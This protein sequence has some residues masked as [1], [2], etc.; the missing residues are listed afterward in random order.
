[1]RKTRNFQRMIGGKSSMRR[2]LNQNM[3]QQIWQVLQRASSYASTKVA[4]TNAL[5][6]CLSF[7]S[8]PTHNPSITRSFTCYFSTQCP[9]PKKRVT[10]EKDRVLGTSYKDFKDLIN[11]LNPDD[12]GTATVKVLTSYSTWLDRTFGWQRWPAKLN[13]RHKHILGVLWPRKYPDWKAL[14]V[15]NNVHEKTY[16]FNSK[17]T[18]MQIRQP[19]KDARLEHRIIGDPSQHHAYRGCWN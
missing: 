18:T 13:K 7:L 14:Q 15:R 9:K 4:R 12:L 16:V 10:K 3:T 11:T 17:H 19:K 5:T 2:L 8:F 6:L 1:M